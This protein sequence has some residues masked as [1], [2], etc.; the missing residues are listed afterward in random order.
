MSPFGTS[1][2]WLDRPPRSA[3]GPGAHVRQ[4]DRKLGRP[5][6]PGRK[7]PSQKSLLCR[8]WVRGHRSVI[9]F[10]VLVVVLCPDRVA[11]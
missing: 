9:M 6:R 10:G 4:A 2:T 3:L 7:R 11:D 8:V 1:A 5:P